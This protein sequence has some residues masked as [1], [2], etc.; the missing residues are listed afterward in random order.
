MPDLRLTGAQGPLDRNRVH[1]D[2]EDLQDA[3]GGGEEAVA[4]A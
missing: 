3:A 4:Y 1:G 2:A